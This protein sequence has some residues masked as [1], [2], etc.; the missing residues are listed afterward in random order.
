MSGFLLLPSPAITHVIYFSTP[1]SKENIVK[2]KNYH[3]PQL[4]F[5]IS[6]KSKCEMN[7][8]NNRKCETCS[9]ENK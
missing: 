4:S 3:E 6:V 7:K 5:V 2:C 1:V 8:A 9:E